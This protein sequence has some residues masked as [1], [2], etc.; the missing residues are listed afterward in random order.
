MPGLLLPFRRDAKQDFANGS[1]Q[2]LVR[3][4]VLQVLLTMAA[5]NK[6]GGELPW[7]TAFGSQL[8]NL[9]FT[10]NDTIASELARVYVQQAFK[11]WLR[12]LQLLEVSV[13]RNGTTLV[14]QIHFRSPHGETHSLAIP[15]MEAQ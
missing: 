1:G 10:N 6:G 9:R 13:V 3:S 14:I 5:G 2:E 12:D 8:T 7:R 11:Q 4:R 15:L